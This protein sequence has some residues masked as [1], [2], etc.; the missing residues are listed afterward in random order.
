MAVDEALLEDA[1]D[2]DVATLRLYRW[3]EPTLS[4]GYFQ[5]YDDRRLHPASASCA[6]VRRQTGGG[7]ILH[8]RE[9]TYSMAL[10]PSHPFARRTQALYEIAHD[11]IIG[12]IADQLSSHESRLKLH[13]NEVSNPVTSTQP[14][15]CF[16]RRATGDVVATPTGASRPNAHGFTLPESGNWKV[17]GSAQRRSC[18]ALLQHGSLLL[19]ASPAAPELPGLA[20]LAGW[21]FSE[22]HAARLASSLEKTLELRFRRIELPRELELK[23][24]ELANKKY[25][26]ASWTKRR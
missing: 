19:R 20:D 14:F 5:R 15:L 7:A 18:G 2:H 9:V 16:E 23:A 1:V 17:L 25:G 6:V 11:A 12:I 22:K 10:P 3:S 8:D 4:L 13:R 21:D 26:V 24:Q